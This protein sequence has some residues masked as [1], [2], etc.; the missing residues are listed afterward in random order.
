[1]VGHPER[2]HH[3]GQRL[4][5]LTV[6]AEE[7]LGVPVIEGVKEGVNGVCMQFYSIEWVLRG[8]MDGIR[9]VGG[10]ERGGWD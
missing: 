10:G 6:A 8:G 3:A 4:G 7:L 1:M 5:R 9:A 2:L